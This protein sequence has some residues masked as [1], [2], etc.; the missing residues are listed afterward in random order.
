MNLEL[1]N[2]NNLALMNQTHATVKKEKLLTLLLLEHLLEIEIRGLHLE[3]GFYNLHNLLVAEFKYSD[4]E[5]ATRLQAMRLLKRY[6]KVKEKIIDGQIS[7]CQAADINRFLMVEK[8][9]E[10]TEI[11]SNAPLALT[12]K[13]GIFIENIIKKV[14]GKGT[15]ESKEILEKLRSI[16]KAKTYLVEIDEEAWQLLQEIKKN[17]GT[18]V[19]DGD[20]T[21]RIFKE[22][23]KKIHAVKEKEKEKEKEKGK[24][25][26]DGQ[27]MNN[28]DDESK[29]V[30]DLRR[31]PIRSRYIAKKTKVHL[32]KQANY[33]CEFVAPLTG[34]RCECKINLQVDHLYPYAWGGLNSIENT[35]ILCSNH[36]FL[37]AEKLFGKEKMAQWRH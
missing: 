31:L 15:R 21:K 14:E 29:K 36:N 13:R 10:L 35:R 32:L 6:P 3:R 30:Q 4:G 7:L 17:E 5:A 34:K 16:S 26:K 8:K 37:Y 33:Q 9:N 19:C 2:L 27:S 22:K 1:K 23:L 28:G 20:I 18:M 25:E 24:K 12:E 11:N